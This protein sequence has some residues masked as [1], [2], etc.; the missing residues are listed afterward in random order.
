MAYLLPR[1]R[2]LGG[3]RRLLMHISM[4]PKVRRPTLADRLSYVPLSNF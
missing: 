1:L 4:P 2:T 3:A